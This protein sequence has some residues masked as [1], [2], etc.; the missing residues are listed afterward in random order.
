MTVRK[1]NPFSLIYLFMS[2]WLLK[3]LFYSVGFHPI[4]SIYFPAQ[5]VAA[6]IIVNSFELAFDFAHF[7]S[8]FIL[9]DITRYSRLVFCFS[10]NGCRA[11]RLSCT[12][13]WYL[14]T[15]IRVLDMLPAAWVSL[16]VGPSSWTELVNTPTRVSTAAHI[17]FS[18]YVPLTQIP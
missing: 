5:M 9:W 17:H 12:G 13:D 3:Y 2:V 15:K 1:N 7:F 8:T 6:L 14:E 11:A 18:I 4:P 16:L 10:C